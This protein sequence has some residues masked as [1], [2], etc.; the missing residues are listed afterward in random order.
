MS[1]PGLKGILKDDI[2]PYSKKPATAENILNQLNKSFHNMP[3]YHFLSMDEK[4]DIIAFLN[5]L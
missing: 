2:L 3:S 1:G 5:T 4:F